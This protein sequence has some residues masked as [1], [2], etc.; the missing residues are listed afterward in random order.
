MKELKKKGSAQ[1]RKTFARHN[2]PDNMFGVKV[3]DLKVIAKTIKGRQSLACEL[4]ETGNADAMYLAGMVADGAQMTKRQLDTWA[5]T[6]TWHMLSSYTVPGVATESEHARELAL[7]WMKSK[8]ELIASTGWC[9]YAGIIAMQADDALDLGEIKKLLDQIVK[10]IDKAPDRV[11]YSMNG[12]VISVGS[13]VTPLLKQ[14]KATAKKIGVVTCDMGDTACKVPLATTYIE[15]IE[16]A[17]RVGK[18]RKTMKC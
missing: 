3:G 14:A 1:T 15:K 12:F 11:R 16:A 13:Y 7:K 9:T 17:G 10:Q 2:A 8:D 5:K 18:K 4:Y 6:S